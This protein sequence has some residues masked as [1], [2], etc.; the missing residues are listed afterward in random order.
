MA[1]GVKGSSPKAEDRPVRTSFNI[2]PLKIK[3]VRYISLMENKD[4]TALVDEAL[5]ILIDKYE[6]KNGEIKIK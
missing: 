6:K 5:Q 2:Y 4:M 3:K 1:K